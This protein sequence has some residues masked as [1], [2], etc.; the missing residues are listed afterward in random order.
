MP[1]SL[2]DDCCTGVYVVLAV[3]VWRDGAR[4]VCTNDT[5][6]ETDESMLNNALQTDEI[7]N[8]SRR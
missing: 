8:R 5:I 6:H 7:G 4:A 2:A 1:L 3:T